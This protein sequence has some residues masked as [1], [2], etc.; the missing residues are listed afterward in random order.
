MGITRFPNGISSFGNTVFG[1]GDILSVAM[2]R[3]EGK[4]DTSVNNKTKVIYVD[5]QATGGNRTGEC[6]KNA[7]ITLQAGMN[8]ARYNF[9]TTTINYDDSRQ[10]VTWIAPGN[11]A[12]R[13]AWTGKNV[14]MIGL[15]LPGTDNG[16][17]LNPSAPSTF[18]FAFSG[19]GCEL[20][21]F[22]IVTETA[23][24]GFYGAPPECCTI[25]HL[26]L[27]GN[28]A[29]TYG[30]YFDETGLKGTKVHDCIVDS[31][32]TAGLYAPTGADAY[33]IQGYIKDNIFGGTTV[34]GIDIDILT[35]YA[36]SI[37]NNDI[38]GTSSASI[39]TATTGILVAG[40]Y[41]DRQP[42]GTLTARDNHYSSAGA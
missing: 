37:K 13:V 23:V 31:Y 18:S 15:G 3:G 28:G 8:M 25:H 1:G 32:I 12:E 16:V 2:G 26:L 29:G 41:C 30:M 5:E 34:K 22:C 36:F 40:N 19:N 42:S 7:C 38:N 24:I 17:T 14:H 20:A 4:V 39:E 10:A 33:A 21:N 6:W 27:Q 11:Y 9:N 35:A